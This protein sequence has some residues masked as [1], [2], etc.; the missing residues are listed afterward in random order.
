MPQGVT[1][2]GSLDLAGA[3][4]VTGGPGGRRLRHRPGPAGGWTSASTLVA[5][6]GGLVLLGSVRGP[7]GA[8]A[9]S[10]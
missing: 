10:R 7:P 1:R 6:L 8:A 2:P 4:T 3:V 9:V 5:G